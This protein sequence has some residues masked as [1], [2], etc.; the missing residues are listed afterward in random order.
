M[1]ALAVAIVI[2]L[3][4]MAAEHVRLVVSFVG[5]TK[6]MKRVSLYESWMVGQQP[7]NSSGDYS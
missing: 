2:A 7:A 3:T 1:F 6:E 4:C 5:Q